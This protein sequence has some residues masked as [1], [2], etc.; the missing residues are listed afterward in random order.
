MSSSH[1]MKLKASRQVTQ[2][3]YTLEKSFFT[4]ATSEEL[5][6]VSFQTELKKTYIHVGL[7]EFLYN[8]REKN[9]I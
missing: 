1:Q 9:T 3:T 7:Y 2:I 6:V 8:S 4:A 5:C